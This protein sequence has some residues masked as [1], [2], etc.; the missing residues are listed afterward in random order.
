[1]KNVKIS[2]RK[3]IEEMDNFEKI[4]NIMKNNKGYGCNIKKY[5]T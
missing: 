5:D 1:M 2:L 4:L 3:E